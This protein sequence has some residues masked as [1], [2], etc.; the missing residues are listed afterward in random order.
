[1]MMKMSRRRAEPDDHSTDS[2]RRCP[3]NGKQSYADCCKPL[4]NG[5]AAASAEALMRSR[6]SAFVM[7][8][9]DYIQRSW[10][11]SAR[12][13]AVNHDNNDAH[14]T[15]WLGLQI[16]RHELIDASHAR[17]EFV[18]RYK[19]NGRAFALHETSRFVHENDH[20]FYLDG[21]IH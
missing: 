9:H 17:V 3:C 15:H 19:I 18:A 2:I 13:A 8:L 16:K 14:K 21:E 20:W 5:S 10:H 7:E 6:Y 1:M 12:P 4:H 11:E